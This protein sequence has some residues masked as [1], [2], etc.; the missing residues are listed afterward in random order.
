MH[1]TILTL[2]CD[3]E[4]KCQNIDISIHQVSQT[5]IVATMP[6]PMCYVPNISLIKP[7][8][9]LRGSLFNKISWKEPL[10]KIKRKLRHWTFR[11]LNF[12]SRLILVKSI[13]Q[14]MPL[15][16]FSVMAAPKSVIK[17][18]RN[19]Q[20]KFLW[21]FIEGHSKWPLLDW[22]TICKLKDVGGLGIRDPLD[23]NK[24][25]GAKIWWKWI[26]HEKKPWDKI[27]HNKYTPQWPKKLLIR[28][29]EKFP[30]SKIWKLD[31]ENISL[32]QR[33]SFWEVRDG[34]NALFNR[35]SWQQEPCIASED[36][37]PMINH[38]L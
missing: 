14:V 37:I 3:D 24:V 30:N 16:L 10:D 38:N 20:N 12:P 7:K 19:I 2:L 25:M 11:A 29:R 21:G 1:L 33:H 5:S 35:D 4:R 22:K 32:I 34:N 27:W 6:I 13:L 28:F 15:Y 17:H 31:Q 36:D 8:I 23:I 18:I 26:T 9:I